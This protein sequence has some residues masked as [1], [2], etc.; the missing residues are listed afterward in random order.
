MAISEKRIGDYGAIGNLRTVALVGLDGSIDWCCLSELSSPSVFGAIVDPSLGG[1]FR[2][3]PVGVSR[4]EQRYLPETNVL[5]TTF[6]AE[7]GRLV[8]TDFFPLTGDLER[9]GAS[10]GPPEIHRLIEAEGQVEVDVVWAP[11]P[12]YARAPVRITR[13]RQGFLAES[14]P[15][16]RLWL[17]GLPSGS[18]VE[19]VGPEVRARLVLGSG[20]PLALVTRW[21]S[22]GRP[23]DVEVTRRLLEG[24]VEAWRRWV[25]TE[26]LAG[27]KEW[28]GPWREMVVRSELVLKL[29]TFDETG[30]IAAAP[31]T[32]LPECIGG[33][34]NWDYR[35]TWIRDARMTAQALLSMGH[36]RE[37]MDFL[38]FA[39]DSAEMVENRLHRLQIMYG[40]RGEAE[41]TE[42]E[43]AHLSGHR[44]SRP[45]RVG[46]EAYEQIQLDVYG[47]LL[48]TAYDVVRMGGELRPSLRHFLSAVADK[49]CEIWQEPDYGIWEMRRGTDHHVYSKVMVW[50]ALDRALHLA[51]MGVLS[52]D[53]R[54]WHAARGRVRE[55][56]LQ[57]GFDPKLNSFVQTFGSQDI[58]AASLLIPLR[59]FLPFEDPRVQGTIDAVLSQLTHD[60]LVHRYRADDGLEGEEGAFSLCSFWLADNLSLSGRLE[61]AERIFEG[62]AGRANHLGLYSE[63]I[64]PSNGE[65]LGNFPQ[66]FTHIGFINSV[67]YLAWAKGREVPV[68]LEGTP[69]HRRS[70]G[71]DDLP[72]R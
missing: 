65:F 68:T 62:M 36:R 18:V 43:L 51:Q 20:R 55:E 4:G 37:A 59:E 71:H 32:S 5:C 47:D 21:A 38:H 26:E 42:R 56:I 24:T 22:P 33:G 31:T 8:V 34:R 52:G 53:T 13:E 70:V 6:E 16:D 3:A 63:Q 69:E 60:G 67:L 49:A 64:D 50:A 10:E 27:A 46:N 9:R 7:G 25:R 28:A 57:R 30:A 39:E 19:N 44:G 15:A 41:L 23:A 72:H 54:R 35:Y 29:M 11:R 1:H 66:A 14:S 12:D 40:L 2:V 17:L 45:V 48:T 58:D 61:E